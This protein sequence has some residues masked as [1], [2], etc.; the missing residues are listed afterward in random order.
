MII[1]TNSD[2]GWVQYSAQTFLPALV[3]YLE[4]YTIISARARYQKQYPARPLCWKSAAFAHEVTEHFTSVVS[5]SNSTR[6]FSIDGNDSQEKKFP[7]QFGFDETVTKKYLDRKGQGKH[8]II[9]FGD[10]LDER[11]ALAIV[12]SQLEAVSKSVTFISL[13]TP[14][15]IIGQLNMLSKHME[16]ICCHPMSLDLELSLVKNQKCFDELNFDLDDKSDTDLLH[17]NL[18]S[19]STLFC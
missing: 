6:P 18:R 19:T 17:E 12:A 11:T 3:P 7:E 10:S 4:N 5:H 15:E 8:E 9:S 16:Y 1:I 13:P 14:L 2:E